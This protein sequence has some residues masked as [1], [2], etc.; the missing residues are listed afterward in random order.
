METK[1][2]KNL[3][4]KTSPAA[5][6][7]IIHSKE[8]DPSRGPQ[9]T[10]ALNPYNY[11]A[12]MNFLGILG[13]DHNH[14]LQDKTAILICEWNGLVSDN[15]PYEHGGREFKENVLYDFNGSGELDK[16]GKKLTNNDPRYILSIGSTGLLIVDFEL[17]NEE[18]AFNSWLNIN[19]NVLIYVYKN[20][21]FTQK[22]LHKKIH[23]FYTNYIK[24]LKD[25]IKNEPI[26]ISIKKRK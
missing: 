2:I 25:R 22:F 1:R 24:D 12:G 14:Q 3:K 13:E 6:L 9:E 19:T 18:E 10:L 7:S 15:L 16:N 26:E 8:F 4:H 17:L 11:D 21:K 23:N 20:F 5:L